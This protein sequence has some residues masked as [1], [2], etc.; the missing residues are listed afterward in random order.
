MTPRTLSATV[1]ALICT[2]SL[3]ACIPLPIP[4]TE[5]GR[6]APS[7]SPVVNFIATEASADATIFAYWNAVAET[8]TSGGVDLEAL[9]AV[10][11]E[12]TLRDEESVA[13]TF[14]ASGVMVIPEY[15]LS[16]AQFEQLYVENRQLFLVVST[17]IDYSLA[18]VV[19]SAG[20]QKHLRPD[21]PRAV[22]HVKMRV[23]DPD[24]FAGLRIAGWTEMLGPGMGC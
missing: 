10:T 16:E 9:E 8:Y 23:D 22:A 20:E 2:L 12:S 13:K 19:D 7:G 14:A 5:P 11:T 4:V 21:A 18:R 1:L 17:C 6:P 24:K 15:R 3:T